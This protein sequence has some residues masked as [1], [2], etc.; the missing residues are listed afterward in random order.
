MKLPPSKPHPE[1]DALLAKVKD[2]PPMTKEQIEA[3]R[4]SWVIGEMMLS[5]LGMTREEAERIYNEALGAE[6]KKQVLK[7]FSSMILARDHR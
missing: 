4:K 6:Y 7:L 2:M 1:L 5:N 3:Q